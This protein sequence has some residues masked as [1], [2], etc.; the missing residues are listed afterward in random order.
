NQT[1]QIMQDMNAQHATIVGGPNTGRI[2]VEDEDPLTGWVTVHL[3]GERQLRT[4]FAN[5]SI[6]LGSTTQNIF[7]LWLRHAHRRN[8]KGI[9]FAPG[10]D[11]SDYYNLWQGFTVV[12]Q[13]GDCS[14]FLQHIKEVI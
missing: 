12:P 6:P 3:V 9:V 10:Q 5:E 13:E 14:L 1:T 11:V 8:V 4:R 2:L 7:D